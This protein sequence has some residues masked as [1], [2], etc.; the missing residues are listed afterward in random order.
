MTEN[1]AGG[2]QPAAERRWSATALP[3]QAI[4]VVEVRRAARH[5]AQAWG[6]EELDWALAQL[7]SE[8]VTNAVLHAAT[9]FDVTLTFDGHR[10]RCA[11]SD[12]SARP[13]RTR[14]Y[15]RDATTGRGMRLVA[16]LSADWGV[17]RHAGGKTVWF[18]L[19]AGEGGSD[20]SVPDLD[21]LLDMLG[22]GEGGSN[23]D[24]PGGT[25]SRRGAPTSSSGPW[26]SWCPRSSRMPSC[27]PGPTS[28]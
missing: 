14:D 11:V 23:G 8:V 5:A 21:A 4:S 22:D 20:G 19:A 16:Q 25:R 13:P 1:G 10:L 6:L 12:G 26:R 27:T 9:P 3:P 18:E 28:T 15:A 7:V 17:E 2:E 24:G